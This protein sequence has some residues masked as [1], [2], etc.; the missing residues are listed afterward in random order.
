MKSGK[1]DTLKAYFKWPFIP[2]IVLAVLS[3][4]LLILDPVAGGLLL[5]ATAIYTVTVVIVYFVSRK[6]IT[7]RLVQ[8]AEQF[9][10]TQD[11][12]FGSISIPFALIG[13]EGDI[14]WVNAAFKECFFAKR[15]E[16]MITTLFSTLERTQLNDDT[17]HEVPFGER[18]YEM[19]THMVTDESVQEM[20]ALTGTDISALQLVYF[21][22][23]TDLL[24][25]KQTL[26]DERC[27]VGLVFFD[28]YEEVMNG[29]ESVRRSLLSALLE[30][31][32]SKYIGSVQGIM[33]KLE[34]DRY[35]IV[36]KHEA[37]ER[38]IADKF[39][40]L[41]DIKT[42]NIGNDLSATLSIGI[43][44]GGTSYD[45]NYNYARTAVDMAL[46]RGGDQVVVK[47]GDETKFYG[48][49]AKTVEKSTRVKARIKAQALR[50]LVQQKDS[51]LIMGHPI[52][53]L[54]CIGAAM[55]IYRV[56]KFSEK[57]VHIVTGEVSNSVKPLLATFAQNPDYADDLFIN[58]EKALEIADKDTLLVVVDTNRPSYT[59][60]PELLKKVPAIVVM[61]HHRQGRETVEN[62]VLS[63]VEP[64]ASSTSE[65]VA[66]IIQ[67]Y[68]DGLKLRQGEAD[69][70]LAGIVMDT[71]NFEDKAGVR[72][73]EAAAYLRRCG[74]DVTHVR[75]LFRD[76]MED[77]KLRA[78]TV[79]TAV[80]Y[81][82]GFII[83]VCPNE[84]KNPNQTVVAAQAANELL[85]IRGIKASFV[86]TEYEGTVYLSA[87]S[88]DEVNVQ[89][90]MEKLGGGGHLSVAGAQFVGISIEEATDKLKAVIDEEV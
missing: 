43:G 52:S 36:I 58:E 66:E 2:A 13:E 83:S 48:G 70:V 51:L 74:A 60:C 45:K 53:D 4:V 8:F 3:I 77:Y 10:K 76:S 33:R 18:T 64:Y 81:K 21:I 75:K 16:R 80:V 1:K 50:E 25:Y 82:E 46:G 40:V 79:R 57:E 17:V 31:K 63:Y 11:E 90:M 22:D 88:I 71:N 19:H 54:D 68:D 69:A 47:T 24:Y 73:F 15:R 42:V 85:E 6:R 20:A 89:V 44:L 87:R 5:G 49:K 27:V 32:L 62:A 67:Y 65:M 9:S 56:A 28:N 37:L 34:K 86:L 39:S 84:G 72:T 12:L 7:K 59:V 41:E 55:G 26:E 30:R 38:L 23:E 35:L 14:Y 61:D 78:E 29:I